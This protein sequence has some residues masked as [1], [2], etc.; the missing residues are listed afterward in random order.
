MTILLP[1]CGRAEAPQHAAC[2]LWLDVMRPELI[3]NDA[4]RHTLNINVLGKGD[5]VL[6]LHRTGASSAYA[7]IAAPTFSVTVS[8][9]RCNT[10]WV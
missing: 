6:E 10:C 7:A 3:D 9:M 1:T 8:S 4:R 5:S 2:H